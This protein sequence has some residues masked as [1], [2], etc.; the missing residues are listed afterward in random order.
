M[1]DVAEETCERKSLKERVSA[2]RDRAQQ[3]VTEM[4][5]FLDQLE[6]HPELEAFAELAS[7]Y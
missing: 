2:R 3:Q 7:K 1:C 6:A 4:T 5:E